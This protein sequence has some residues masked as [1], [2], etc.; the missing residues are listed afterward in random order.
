MSS[1][2]SLPLGMFS[3]LWLI[4]WTLRVPILGAQLL[5]TRIAVTYGLGEAGIGH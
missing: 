1:L 2:R 4:G 3:V 5:A